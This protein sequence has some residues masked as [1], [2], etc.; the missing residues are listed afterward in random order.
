MSY[1]PNLDDK[2]SIYYW[3]TD[4]RYKPS[5]TRSSKPNRTP[6]EIELDLYGVPRI[7]KPGATEEAGREK[8]RKGGLRDFGNDYAK[9]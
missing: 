2:D 4:T 7:V 5:S 6:P 9:K 1:K 8:P 3:G